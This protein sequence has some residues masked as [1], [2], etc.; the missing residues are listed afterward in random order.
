MQEKLWFHKNFLLLTFGNVTSKLGSKI[1]EVILAWWLIE[2]TGSAKLFGIVTAAGLISIVIFNIFSGV[3]VDRFNKKHLLI[4]SDLASAFVCIVVGII[5]INDTLHVPT[6]IVAAILLGASNS[7]FTPTL[8]AILPSLIKKDMII[9]A[10]SITTVIGQVITVSA[11]LLAGVMIKGFSFGL[12]IAFII[13]G[14]TYFVSA[15]SEFFIKYYHD[16]AENRSNIKVFADIKEG[17]SYVRSQR[18][19]L[20]LLYVSAFVNFFI[21][22]Y[23]TMLPMFFLHSYSDDGSLY[24]YALGA[25]ALFAII[26][27]IVISKTKSNNPK[28]YLLKKELFYCGLPIILLQLIH[29][30]YISIILVGFFGYYLTRF[31]VHFFSIVQR[32]V[33]KD[34]LGRVFSI[35]F[36]V[37]LSIMPLGN[38]LS[39]LF[40]TQIIDFVFIITGAGVIISTLLIKA[41]DSG[42]VSMDEE[43][44]SN[45]KG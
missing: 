10:N 30:S 31:N 36:M 6:L 7:L 25:E 32:E 2:K 37:A 29:V 14:I 21:A 13:N 24:S 19:L 44:L 15:L 12:G 20:H 3:I 22:A 41:N 11:P 38:L 9:N 33:D 42:V 43:S 1:Y 18:W 8:K 17:Y 28:P 5:V 23:N 35:I 40:S 16:T 34:K 26:A 45:A 27:G 39:G 4:I